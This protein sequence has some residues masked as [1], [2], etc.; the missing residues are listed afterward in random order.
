VS[1]PWTYWQDVSKSTAIMDISETFGR[2]T[3]GPPVHPRWRRPISE[4]PVI[5]D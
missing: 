2:S 3:D 4:A 1:I 5:G